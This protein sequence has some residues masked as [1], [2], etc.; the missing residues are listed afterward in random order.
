M[1]REQQLTPPGDMLCPL[2]LADPSSATPAEVGV[3]LHHLLKRGEKWKAWALWKLCCEASPGIKGEL[4]SC[5]IAVLQTA[6]AACSALREQSVKPH[7]TEMYS[8]VQ[9][10]VDIVRESE[11]RLAS[12]P[13]RDVHQQVLQSWRLA[14][15]VSAGHTKDAKRLVRGLKAPLLRTARFEEARLHGFSPKLAPLRRDDGKG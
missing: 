14:V 5:A 7:S 15:L 2:L 10:A 11:N 6:A 12:T 4:G 3:A 13:K 8:V 9:E 1:M